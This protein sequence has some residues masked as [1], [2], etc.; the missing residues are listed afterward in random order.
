LPPTPFLRFGRRIELA[1]L[2]FTL[3]AWGAIFLLSGKPK[4]ASSTMKD[5]RA[6]ESEFA[7]TSKG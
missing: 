4:W 3:L 7:N 5:S 6:L 2:A 1:V